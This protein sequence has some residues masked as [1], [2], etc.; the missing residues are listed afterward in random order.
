MV[1]PLRRCVRLVHLRLE[2]LRIDAGDDLAALHLAVV[3]GP[4]SLIW[5]DTCEPTCTVMTALSVPAEIAAVT[6]P[7]VTSAVRHLRRWP[8]P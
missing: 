7:R 8:S 6:G 4:S 2:E 3:V 5:P 1:C